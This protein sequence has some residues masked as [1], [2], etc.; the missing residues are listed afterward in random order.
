MRK[1]EIHLYLD[2]EA[3]RR[4]E[5]FINICQTYKETAE[6]LSCE[7][8]QINTTIT[9]FLSWRYGERLFCHLWDFGN[10]RER[11]Y[12]IT[13][14]ECIGTNREIRE[15]HNIEKMLLAGEFS[16]SNPCATDRKD[17]VNCVGC[18]NL[19]YN[20]GGGAEC[21]IGLGRICPRIGFH[22]RREK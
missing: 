21:K 3:V 2:A 19:L 20:S 6:Q 17:K 11:V 22:F 8:S 7:C 14:R 16:W 15:G 18:A 10:D 9:H 4:A 13:L 1:K 5:P 12:E